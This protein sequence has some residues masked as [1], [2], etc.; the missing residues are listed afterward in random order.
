MGGSDELSDGDRFALGPSGP[1]GGFEYLG[2]RR[3]R[4]GAFA[5]GTIRRAAQILAPNRMQWFRKD[6]REVK[7]RERGCGTMA[8]QKTPDVL[9]RGCGT[10]PQFA[11]QWPGLSAASLDS[12]HDARQHSAGGCLA[13]R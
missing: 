13:R 2:A 8:Q 9:F 12:T 4:M 7:R 10:R 1:E 5:K 6:Q 3:S 11:D